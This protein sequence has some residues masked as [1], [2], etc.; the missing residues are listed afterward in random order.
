[1]LKF[2]KRM[3]V[4]IC[5]QKKKK[6]YQN[7]QQSCEN[8]GESKPETDHHPELELRELQSPVFGFG[9]DERLVGDDRVELLEQ[10]DEDDAV[11]SHQ[12]R[13]DQKPE[14]K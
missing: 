5:L 7:S 4:D 6:N 12:G 14:N 3:L 9:L 13:S 10:L 11:E 1:M 8:P 2:H